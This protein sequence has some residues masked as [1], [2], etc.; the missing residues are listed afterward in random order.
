MV[1]AGAVIGS[2][3]F[4]GSASAHVRGKPSFLKIENSFVDYYNVNVAKGLRQAYPQ[5]MD[6]NYHLPGQK[7]SF[8]IDK[9]LMAVSYDNVDRM[10]LRWDFGDGGTAKGFN[11]SRTYASPGTKVLQ[12]YG[13]IAG[14][15]EKLVEATALQIFP[16]DSYKLPDF[17]M[18]VNGREV[19]NNTSEIAVKPGQQVTLRV[20]QHDSHTPTGAVWDFGDGQTA[21]GLEASHTYGQ[22]FSEAYPT[23][24]LSFDGSFFL[25]NQ[26]HLKNPD[27]AAATADKQASES[28]LLK[29]IRHSMQIK[30]NSIFNGG[31]TNYALAIFVLLFAVIAGALHSLTPGHGK[32]ILAALLI[33]RDDNRYRDLAILTA[34]IT[35]A[36]TLV[37]YV[38]GF[39]LLAL[40]KSQSA[41]SL[42]PYFEK[43]SAILVV[44]LALYLIYTGI[45]RIAHGH[46]HEHSHAHSHSHSHSHSHEHVHGSASD[47]KH[48]HDTWSLVLAGT[49]GGIVPCIDALSLML[50]AAGLGHTG[51][52]LILV[53][54]FSLGLAGTITALGVVVIAGKRRL[55]LSK[56]TEESISRYAPLASGAIILSLA[57]LTLWP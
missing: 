48:A 22:H 11:A 27:A 44:G 34:S 30:L 31:G 17:T 56:Q 40:S 3:L 12:V 53:V 2:A 14:E 6:V 32:T 5:S 45:R 35:I 43:A 1:L 13:H 51:F 15:P 28:G 8:I 57:V 7:I 20:L 36:H 21:E 54:F 46:T 9:K 52:G 16:D 39:V 37:I 50:L 26:L 41:N 24:R 18:S 19:F 10:S 55:S 4:A 23:I 47:N 29:T 38:I 33:G 49:G 25:D 42:V